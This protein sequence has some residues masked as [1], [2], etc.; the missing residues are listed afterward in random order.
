MRTILIAENEAGVR[1]LLA[2]TLRRAGYRV[3]SAA[4]GQAAISLAGREAG[5]IDL[6]ITDIVMERV[7][8][9]DLYAS[10]KAERPE[11]PVLFIS[12]YMSREP[13]EGAFLKKPFTPDELVAKVRELLP[14]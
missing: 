6:L 2:E 1:K 7:G 10:L 4:G 13:V 14:R 11:L 12:G 3:L 5:P 9:A 8:G